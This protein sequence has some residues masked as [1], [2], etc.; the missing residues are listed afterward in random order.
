MATHAGS[1]TKPKRR[2]MRALKIHEISAVDVPAQEGAVAVIMKRNDPAK[3]GDGGSASQTAENIAKGSALTSAD[4]GHTHLIALVGH[5]GDKLVAGMTSW[6]DDHNH[7]WIMNEA[8]QVVIGMASSE[9]GEAHAHTVGEMSKLAEEELSAAGQT[10]TVGSQEDTQM[11]TDNTAKTA[12]E[13][14]KEIEDLHKQVARSNSIAALNDVEKAHFETLEGDEAD[15]FLAKSVDDRKVIL[16]DLAKAATEEDP[17]VYTT[18]DGIELRKSH[19]AGFIVMAKSND[20]LR[21][22]VTKLTDDKSVAT[23]EKRAETELAHMPGDIGTRAA[24]LKAID[25]IED[26]DQREASLNALKAQNEILSTAFKVAGNGGTPPP[27]SPEDRLDDLA[28]EYQKAN[29][30]VTIEQSMTEVLKTDAGH[31]LYAKS[32]N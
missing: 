9:S 5:G 7:P 23:Y 22:Q 8:S 20:A 15:G 4:E 2:I 24:M 21:D 28:K 13:L 19:G 16:S 26:K 25:G 1:Q 14:A 30:T 29:P 27:G 12:D 10:G 6:Q 11:P 31:E 3:K 32:V 18:K 17:V